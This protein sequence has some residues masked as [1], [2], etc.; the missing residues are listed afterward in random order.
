LFASPKQASAIP[1]RPTP[2]FFSAARRVT[3]WA[4]FLV[5]SSNFWFITILTFWVGCFLS[6]FWF[7]R[8]NLIGDPGFQAAVGAVTVQVNR[9]WT[10]MHANGAVG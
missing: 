4:R 2:N 9:E 6:D 5:S 10:P 1:A 3:D 7:S 8:E